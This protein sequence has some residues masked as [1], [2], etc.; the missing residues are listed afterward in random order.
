MVAKVVISIRNGTSWNQPELSQKLA[1]LML[2]D[3][4]SLLNA[5]PPVLII[6]P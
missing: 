3:Q 2:V 6:H 4:V 1:G 5:D